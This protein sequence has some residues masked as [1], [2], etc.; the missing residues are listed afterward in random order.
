[1]TKKEKQNFLKK[2]DSF[3]HKVGVEQAS[4]DHDLVRIQK[5][6]DGSIS[7]ITWY[8][9]QTYYRTKY[10][11]LKTTLKEIGPFEYKNKDDSKPVWQPVD[12]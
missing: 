2:Y 11:E 10:L 5:H 7:V 9:G 12:Q 3:W 6:K 8:M 1:M 4:K